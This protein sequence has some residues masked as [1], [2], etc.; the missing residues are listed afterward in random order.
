MRASL[1][2]GSLLVL[3]ALGALVSS[4]VAQ[5]DFGV[6]PGSVRAE[7]LNADG[8]A[9]FHAGSHPAS[10]TIHFDLETEANGL[11]EGGAARGATI[12]LPPGL[13]GNP[14][15]APA[16][17]AQQFDGSSALC[18]PATQIGV[19]RANVVGIG[20]VVGPLYN[21]DPAPGYVAQLAFK[22]AGLQLSQYI[23]VSSEA[24]YGL[25][26][27]V[28]N[29]PQ[30]PTSVTETLWGT[31]AESS[32]DAQRTESAING[33]PP[34]ASD[35]PLLAYLT[36]PASCEGAAPELTVTVDSLLMPELSTTE[37]GRVIG[38]GGR[39]ASISGCEA[40]PFSPQISASPTAK[41]AEATSGL[42][43]EMT[44]PD[45]GLLS[46][47]N[48]SE[49]EPQK[50]EVAL[51]EGVTLNP[52][53][54][55][56]LGSCTPTQYASAS[57]ESRSGEGCPNASKIGTL[58]VETPLLDEAVEG[59]VYLATPH[60]NPFDSALAIYLVA[61]AAQRG[62]QI[63]Q[64]GLLLAD[65]STG[66]LTMS[67]DGLPPLP[68][69]TFELDLR[70]G[71]RAPL[72]MPRICGAYT[73]E[74]KLYSFADPGAA[75]VREAS[76]TIGSG[77]NGAACVASEAQ[78]P[79]T[80]SLEAGTVVPLA[81]TYSPLLFK[82]SRE[83]GSQRFGSISATLPA[84]LVGKLAGIPSCPDAQIAAASARSGE[85]QGAV[86]LASPSCPGASRL[87][88]AEILAGAGSEPA[89]FA[90]G[91]YVAGPYQGAPLSLA[92]IVPAV[93]GPFDLGVVVVRLAL[94]V[95]P[96][97]AQLHLVSDPIPSVLHGIP[98][99]VRTI[100]F[101]LDRP[102]FTLNPTNCEAMQI[103][104]AETSTSGQTATLA[105]RFKAAACSGLPF[106]PKLSASTMAN[107]EFAGH[108]AS[109]HLQVT[110][111]AGQANLRSLKVDLPQLLPARSATIQHACPEKVFAIDP[112]A[113]P[114]ASVI[115]SATVATPMLAAAMNGPVYLVSHG[116]AGFPD[117]VLLLQAQGIAIELSGEL[118]VDEHNFTSAI[119]RAIPDVPIRRLDL[120]LSE[121]SRSILVAG[122]KLCDDALRMSTAITGQNGAREKP[123]VGVTVEGCSKSLSIASHSLKRRVLRLSVYVPS[124][125]K[126][127]VR[128]KGLPTKSIR[129]KGRQIV[130]FKLT[131]KQAGKLSTRV[132][133]EFAPTHGKR[134]SRSLRVAFKA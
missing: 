24:G 88:A 69:A 29:F 27:T 101:Q 20:E 14:R 21:V 91:V 87:G 62:L 81:G 79:N 92:V 124:A 58:V 118:Y 32:H 68:Y 96:L 115:G 100:S 61:R 65:P 97:T 108:G 52:S 107:G 111:V 34:V 89:R 3:C 120:V 38:E 105:N 131:Q 2:V 36:L 117:I 77:A 23:S 16:C 123:S 70:E 1:A 113:C 134:Q 45:Q 78:L 86:E 72:I 54:A 114:A 116:G 64:A 55:S 30:P 75:A 51:P 49:T 128:G 85:G 26:V 9:D 12:D 28:P 66:Q 11:P 102:G 98:L 41:L 63:K 7:A 48:I 104:G 67:V 35:A 106:A 5:A 82:L 40:V 44:L 95:D 15:A 47:G 73:T 76:F 8:T 112:A 127:T 13:I 4:T 33:G 37:S 22:T 109:L 103:D 99:D 130:T 90:G 119:F 74:A 80:P 93:A 19:L 129:A 84:G 59:S 50:L 56:G 46:P 83:D 17:S 18:S 133:V 42:S 125:G 71:P 10:F 122:A 53:L 110:T 132:S 126:V 57:D 39:P 43:L 60:D 6:V 31:P 94:Y 121:G 25:H